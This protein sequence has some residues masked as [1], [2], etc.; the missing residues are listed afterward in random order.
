MET[1]KMSEE[2]PPAYEAVTQP[3]EPSITSI[4]AS[5]LHTPLPPSTSQAPPP[6]PSPTSNP[7]PRTSSFLTP[8]PLTTPGTLS[9]L[10]LRRDLLLPTTLTLHDPS[11][12]YSE[13][14]V[15]N[16]RFGSFPHSTLLNLPWG[17]QVR[18]SAV[19][20]GSRG[21]K[22]HKNSKKRKRD[23]A[24]P[25]IST[26]NETT[27]TAANE[28]EPTQ[29]LLP[30]PK[31][32]TQAATG[33]LHILLPTPENWTASLPHRTQVVYTPD[34]SYILHRMRVR[35]G[36]T[37][38]E[39][40]SGSGSFTHAAA[41]AVF[42][43]Y[44]PYP[45]PNELETQ[46]ATATAPKK[47]AEKDRGNKPKRL[48]KVW[49]YEFHAQRVEKVRAEICEH[50]LDGIVEVT[51]RDVCADGFSVFDE[52]G[53]QR[54]RADAVFLDLPAPWYVLVH[55]VFYAMRILWIDTPHLSCLTLQYP[56]TNKLPIHTYK[57]Q[58]P[59]SDSYNAQAKPANKKRTRLALPHL[60]RSLH[61]PPTTT[62]APTPA[63][64]AA[65]AQP[66]PSPSTTSSSSPLNPLTT[67]HICTFSPCIEQVQRTVTTLR[68]LHYTSIEMV[69]LQHRRLDIRRDRT[70]LSDLRGGGT[71]HTPHTVAEAVSRLKEVEGRFRTFHGAGEKG[72][73][74]T[75]GPRA[76]GK[77]EIVDAL[78]RDR[79]YRE[80]RL[81]SRCE[82]EVKSHTSYLVF[83]VLPR[84]WT[85][86][87]EEKAR[88]R[89]P[90]KADK[91]G[92]V[93]DG[94]GGGD[95]DDGV[96]DVEGTDEQPA[97]DAEAGT[98]ASADS[99]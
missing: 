27:T 15:T 43:G 63:S 41:R 11:S 98:L 81:V 14:R 55:V 9:I 89:W 60:T 78:V 16:T 30:E 91:V 80:G 3:I 58:K 2:L 51:H 36:S 4:S 86:R 61:S 23:D 95:E 8:P 68:Q 87:D 65:P 83:A 22:A 46:R 31:E 12:G 17:S 54:V 96:M 53:G 90:I 50:G 70:P 69:E 93:E 56:Y 24:A 84:E 21:R 74:V 34:Y 47:D 25:S 79:L 5:P 38:I 66:P 48:G 73:K 67:T 32:A 64:A 18:A 75:K 1:G 40:G 94:G 92:R 19:D 85:A 26:T 10:H 97:D 33:F 28:E 62:K 13:G 44:P 76:R 45:P 49:S 39:A 57:K 35:P 77:K 72:E 71:T 88:R 99:I 7:P 37:L 6:A 42:S 29:T 59:R 82:P 20:T 52:G